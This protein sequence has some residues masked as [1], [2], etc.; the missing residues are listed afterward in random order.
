MTT[1]AATNSQVLKLREFIN[2]VRAE[3]Y[4]DRGTTYVAEHRAYVASCRYL[5]IDPLPITDHISMELLF[6]E[7]FAAIVKIEAS[8]DDGLYDEATRQTFAMSQLYRDWT[9]SY[10]GHMHSDIA[11]FIQKFRFQ[12]PL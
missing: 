8:V 2:N 6:V 3:R 11:G 7:L 4:H 5:K 1:T 10:W 9:A 12:A